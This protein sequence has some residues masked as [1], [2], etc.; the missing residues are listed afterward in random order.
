MEIMF[1][2]HEKHLKDFKHRHPLHLRLKTRSGQKSLR[3][4]EKILCCFAALLLC[5]FA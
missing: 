3:L 2:L 1:C 5:A 4:C